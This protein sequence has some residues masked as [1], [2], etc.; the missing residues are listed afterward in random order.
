MP[1]YNA[2]VKAIAVLKDSPP[3]S[4]IHAIQNYVKASMM[5]ANQNWNSKQFFLALKSAL[6]RG[7]I[8]HESSFYQLSPEM[9]KRKGNLMIETE[10][11]HED[12]KKEAAVALRKSPNKE[13]PAKKAQLVKKRLLTDKIIIY[14][15]DTP[16]AEK[17]ELTTIDGKDLKVMKTDAHRKKLAPSKL[18]MIAKSAAASGM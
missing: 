1:Y 15:K 13:E 9:K 8:V 6:E 3:G 4:P 12:A 10:R 14:A 17:M 2:I 18:K 11:R 7:D 16:D 5:N